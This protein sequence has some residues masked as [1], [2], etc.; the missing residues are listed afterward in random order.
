MKRDRVLL[1]RTFQQHLFP[2][3]HCVFVTASGPN[4][5]YLLLKE[6]DEK[7]VKLHFPA[8]GT[9]L[10]VPTQTQAENT[11]VKV[12]GRTCHWPTVLRDVVFLHG[13]DA[14]AVFFCTRLKR[15][16]TQFAG[17]G[18]RVARSA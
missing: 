1:Q 17:A 11:G 15:S 7:V 8:V 9:E 12:D 5:V 2:V 6:L 16:S 10:S 14:G 18:E 4:D 3:A 13:S